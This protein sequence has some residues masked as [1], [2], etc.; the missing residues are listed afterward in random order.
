MR[1]RAKGEGAGR[2]AAYTSICV[3]AV[4]VLAGGFALY[5]QSI[6]TAVNGTTT[7]FMSQ[8][9]DHDAQGIR[10]Q[11][12]NKWDYLDSLAQR[13]RLTRP[14]DLED[15]SYMLGV[16]TQSTSFD[17]IYLVTPEGI[18]YDNTY[19][20]TR[21][22]NMVWA[23][24]Y[25]E[26]GDHFV[27]RYTLEEREAW[28][29]YLVFGA[30]LPSPL[31]Y[32]SQTIESI[33]GM[34]PISDLEGNMRFESFDGQGLA[35]VIQSTG[36]IVTASKYYGGTD[37]QNYFSELE[38]ATFYEGSFEECVSAVEQG[39]DAFIEYGVDGGRY[40]A[41]LKAIEDT[42]WYLVVK[43]SSSVMA[44]QVNALVTRSLIFFGALGLVVLGVLIGI[45]RSVRSARIARE[46]ERAKSTFLANMSHEIR[47][48][49]NGIVGLQY[50]MRQNLNDPEKMGTYLDQAEA[51]AEYLK[52]VI[53]DV[54]DMSKI[55]SSQMELF[56]QPFDLENML[57]DIGLLAEPQARARG[58]VFAI[59]RGNLAATRVVGDE[60]RIKQVVVNLIGNA[61]KFTPE[62]GS[63]TLT[64]DQQVEDGVAATKLIVADTGCGMSADFLERLWEP[65]EQERRVSSQ[66]GTGLGT[67][68]SKVLV[69][70][71]G[72]TI[73]VESALG[74]G[75]TFTVEIPLAV[76]TEASAA[77]EG[78]DQAS[79]VSLDGMRVLVAED[80]DVNRMIIVDI[81]SDEGCEVT[82]V[83]DGAAAVAAFKESAPG[84]FD[85][86]LMDLQMPVMDGY[87]AAA[88][89]RALKRSDAQRVPI[90]ALTANA[91]RDDVDRALSSGMND[92]VT[93]PLDV[94]RLLDKLRTCDAG[95]QADAHRQEEGS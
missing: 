2:I 41:T 19:L 6:S 44:D 47:T 33:V 15:V 9:A 95:R 70:A 59:E 14:E 40:Y 87:K 28:G 86:V 1:G 31:S 88:G 34:V 25:R 48:P 66:N 79:Q 4:A 69:E 38:R 52:S 58:L 23:E 91:F 42:D 80:N 71:M 11:I 29:E 77:A 63:I 84:T 68:L 39:V 60:M 65:F 82:D 75:T 45:Y 17:K 57:R 83:R 30:K 81:L 62:G 26:S 51:S 93:K 67:T 16:E 90:M 61:L 55:E 3:L 74:K 36:D 46:S 37:G 64:V 56:A 89:I 35:I 5:Q 13:I 53:T 22:D 18:M 50:L 32:G 8:I 92:V 85:V 27:L 12:I 49:L 24:A 73:D 72:G 78:A 10:N 43:A 94:E 20:S 21:L 76:D 54:L 7:S